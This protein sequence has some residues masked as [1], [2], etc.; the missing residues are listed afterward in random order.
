[1]GL[2]LVLARLLLASVFLTAG[3]AKLADLAGTRRAIVDFGIPDRFAV[4]GGIVLPLSELAVA[5]ALIPTATAP[6]AAAAAALLLLAFIGGIA[7]A[8]AKGRAPDCHCFG[9]L[10]SAP[11][12][13]RAIARNAALLAVAGFV[14]IGGWS[15]AGDSATGWLRD[16]STAA[17]VGAAAAVV[18]A[19]L[20]GFVVWFCL[21]LLRQNGRMLARLEAL[22]SALATGSGGDAVA[23]VD[24]P[25]GGLPVGA[26]AP[27]FEL[28]SE[29]GESHSLA[30]LLADGRELLLVFSD[31]DC[32]PCRELFPEV[33]GWQTTHATR[34]AIAVILSGEASNSRALAEEH[35]IALALSQP[36]RE[37][38]DAY[39]AHATPMAVLVGADGRIR[40]STVGGADAIR[41]LVATAV[42][43][44]PIVLQSANGNGRAPLAPQPELGAPVPDLDLADLA[45]RPTALADLL[46]K[47]SVL[48]FWDPGCGFCQQMLSDL[49][50]LEAEPR[51]GAPQLVVL[52]AGDADAVREQAI[53]APVLLD[54][55]A[56]AMDAFGAG[57]T[58]MGVLVEDGTIASPLAGGAEA[59]MEL[60]RS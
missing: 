3:L 18:L 19:A 29:T 26:D 59:V 58:P 48:I 33:A 57:G 15:D 27:D 47:R 36:Q 10:H 30:S 13:R 11:V 31:P 25:G 39:L 22:E 4:V 35:G 24:L 60:I 28:P 17:V 56:A 20:I 5:I 55:D 50:A 14:A 40:S 34:L 44:P 42:H 38:A 52:S 16:A 32:G 1:M 8:M 6:Y 43:P 2:A 41:N 21:Q 37:V 23:P 51:R 53:G 9:Q 54:P 46:G 45:G 12:G 7:N 49:R